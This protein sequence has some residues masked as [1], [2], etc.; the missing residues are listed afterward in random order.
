MNRGAVLAAFGLIGLGVLF[1]IFNILGVSSDTTWP[2][3]FIASGA[4]CFLP[5]FLWPGMRGPLAGLAIPGALVI[6]LGLIFQ[7]N[8]LSHD[9]NS[10]AYAWILL[11][12]GVGLGLALAGWIGSWGGGIITIGWWLFILSVGVFSAFA[13]LF[14]GPALRTVAP[15]FLILFGVWL[16]VRS[17][18]R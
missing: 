11:T 10:W 2:V 18:R 4:L 7:Y 5:A 15:V 17:F 9:W 8:V 12:G 3:I 16:F 13:T 6:L 14:G 1:L